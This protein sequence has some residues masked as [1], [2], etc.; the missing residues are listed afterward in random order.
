MRP[1]AWMIDMGYVV[2]ASSGQFNLD[3][4]SAHQLIEERCSR[5]QAF[6]FN[7]F[8]PAYGVP[9]GLQRFYEA[10][11]RYGMK[12]RLQPMQSG[13]PGANRQRRV[14]VDLCAHLVW[15]ASK[16]EVSTLVLTAGDQDLLPAVEV[17]RERLGKQ[18]ILFTYEKNVHREL[19]Q[20]ASEWWLF[21]T[22][23]DRLAR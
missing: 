2:K 17:V 18:L 22:D 3:Y 16:T 13:P 15:Q 7:G 11:R 10:M 6:L 5:T 8:D 14:D 9:A 23:A 21:E 19:A 20:S 1:T 4:V 12:I